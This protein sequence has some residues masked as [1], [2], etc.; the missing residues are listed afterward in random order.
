M[1]TLTLPATGRPAA[2]LDS[3]AGRLRCPAAD[4]AAVSIRIDPEQLRRLVLSARTAAARA[5]APYSNFRVGAALVMADDPDQTVITGVNVENSSYGVTCCAERSALFDAAGRG[6]RRLRYLAVSTIDA[7]DRPLAE[8]SPCGVC[9]QTLRE[10]SPPSADASAPA[11]VLIDGG[12][13]ATLC[14]IL[15]VAQLLPYGFCFAAP[16]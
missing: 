13:G 9:R 3:A 10:F 4:A 11:L 15:T 7:L 14:D 2:L 6:W 8:R 12:D 5:Y 1:L 16:P